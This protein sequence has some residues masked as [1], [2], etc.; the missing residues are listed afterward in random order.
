MTQAQL[1][2][3]QAQ[4]Q[5]THEQLRVYTPSIGRILF[6]TYA[7]PML[8]LL[9]GSLLIL[10]LSD[11]FPGLLSGGPLGTLAAVVV[12]LSLMLL[13]WRWAEKR[14]K[15]TSLFIIFS[16]LSKERRILQKMLKSAA[17]GHAIDLYTI[18]RQ[19]DAYRKAAQ[20]Y[21]RVIEERHI[22]AVAKSK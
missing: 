20:D 18:E 4:M 11:L 21:L 6:K 16:S 10:I 14:W 2:H 9:I 8:A 13:S 7:F 3:I 22:Q 5:Q 1:D 19:L 15:G 12:L 17:M